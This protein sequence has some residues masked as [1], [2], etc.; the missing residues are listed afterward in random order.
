[1]WLLPLLVLAPTAAAGDLQSGPDVAKKVPELKVFAVTGAHEDKDV[2]YTAERK[3]KPTIYVF[4]QAD[5][6]VRPM[7]RFLKTLDKE[8]QKDSDDAYV[9]AVWLTDKHKETKE[10]L[11]RAQQSLQFENTALTY[12]KGKKD[13]PQGWN[14]NSDAHMTV[15]VVHN[16]KVA[17]RFG[18]M[19]VN[20]TD[21]KD[22]RAALKKAVKAKK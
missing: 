4:I 18:Y 20:E 21:V 9:I 11:P 2:N 13:G 17:A 22:V 14:V 19:S 8:V 12:F 6:W 16:Q 10:Y 3:K 15:V 5:K 1:M 7:A